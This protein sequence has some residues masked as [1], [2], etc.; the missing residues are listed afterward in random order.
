MEDERVMRNK[1]TWILAVV[2]MAFVAAPAMA[3]E[4]APPDVPAVPDTVGATKGDVDGNGVIDATDVQ[5]VNQLAVGVIEHSGN[6][7]WTADLNDDGLV[8]LQD[9]KILQ[10]FLDGDSTK[11]GKAVP[12][13]ALPMVLTLLGAGLVAVRRR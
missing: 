12:L 6:S 1:S 3:D 2:V 7:K 9:A 10:A 8:D 11:S 13:T 4:V 5:L